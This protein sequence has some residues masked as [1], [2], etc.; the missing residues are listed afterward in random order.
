MLIKML[1]W[2]ILIYKCGVCIFCFFFFFLP[3]LVYIAILCRTHHIKKSRERNKLENPTHTV[4]V[5]EYNMNSWRSWVMLLMIFIHF[6]QFLR[7]YKN[8]HYIPFIKRWSS[9]FMC[10][11][12]IKNKKTIR[13]YDIYIWWN[14]PL[15]KLTLSLFYV[16]DCI[17]NEC[18]KQKLEEGRK[19]I[20]SMH[21][22][23]WMHTRSKNQ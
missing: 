17:K 14:S 18:K 16:I 6:V 23:H 8:I 20:H 2:W 12:V 3:F 11:F 21:K 10:L 15:P 7:L 1:A 9:F 5:S 19:R 13:V 22:Q 4:R